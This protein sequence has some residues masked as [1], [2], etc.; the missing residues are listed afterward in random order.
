VRGEITFEQI[1]FGYEPD[2]PV[3]Q[4]V[5]LQV[6]PGQ[7]I[8][9][10]GGTGAGKSTLAALVARLFDPWSGRVMLDGHDIK[11]VALASLRGQV[12][13]VLQDPFLF[14]LS[15][16][17]NIAYGAPQAMPEQIQAAAQAAGAHD[18][19]TRLPSGYDTVIGERGATLSGGE[20][21]RLSIA[22]ALLRDAPVLILDEPTSALDA[23]TEASVLEAM[24]RLMA[25]RTTLMIAHRLSTVRDADRI[26]VLEHGAIIEDGT[27]QE[28][29]QRGGR[30]AALCHAMEGRSQ[31]SHVEEPR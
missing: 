27:H 24:R 20:R 21:Q 2:R 26:I 4:G 18:F 3:L 28:L 25:G 30:Y 15:I 1:V 11:D 7:S 16:A 17:E 29:L 22:R 8:A 23:T 10:V 9:I 6:P 19:I 5:S 12:S 13:L 14:P 31:S